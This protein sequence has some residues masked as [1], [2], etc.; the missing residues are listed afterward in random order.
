MTDRWNMI[1]A[2]I[3]LIGDEL[4]AGEVRDLN[5]PFF[6]EQLTRAGFRIRAVRFL[7][8]DTEAIVRELREALGCGGLLV[9]CGGLGPTSDDRTTEAV[10]AAVGRDLVLEKEQWQRIRQIFASFRGHEPPPGNEKQAMVP[11]GSEILRNGLGTAP[12]YVIEEGDAVVAVLPGPPRE[13]RPMLEAEL[14]PWLDRRMPDRGRMVTRVFRVFGLAESEV[15][16][17]LGPLEAR[18]TRLR[19]GYQFHFPEILAKLRGSSEDPAMLDRASAELMEVLRP[20]VYGTGAETLPAVLG[21]ELAAR[22]LRIA[23][24]ESCTGGLVAKLL[25]DTPGSSGWMETGWVTYSNAAK[26]R[27]L[28]V[29]A[30]LL[31]R[32]G[33]VSE[34]VAL[35]MLEGALE[36]SGAQVGIAV[37]GIAGPEGGT[38]DKPVGTVCIAWGRRGAPATAKT[39]GFHWDREYNRMISAWAAMYHLYQDLMVER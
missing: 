14:L 38:A 8:D 15:G 7:A 25:T 30:G 21:R 10:A 19:V 6:A 28:G 1:G 35:A 4:L 33:A 12:G 2:A 32:H 16:H 39:Y 20:H 17:R 29:P 24:A 36:R 31:S 37:T 23:T 13:N 22:G 11:R 18:Y 9:V 26:E 3:L 34:P 5:G 27:F